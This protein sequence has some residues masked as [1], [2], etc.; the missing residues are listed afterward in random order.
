MKLSQKCFQ[1]KINIIKAF[2]LSESGSI[3]RDSD[4]LE[5]LLS[6]PERIHRILN[7]VLYKKRKVGN[8]ICFIM[9][10]ITSNKVRSRIAKY[11]LGKGCTR[12]QKS[13]FMADLPVS[14]YNEINEALVEVQK[15]YENNDSILIVPLSEDYVKAM[16]VIG[17]QVDMDL[18]MH[19][20]TTLFF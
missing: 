19:V 18:M 6:L 11:L 1:E 20:K 17:Q 8:M 13:I 14:T 15:L 16:K 5:D 3:S 7:I 12:V 10:D 4:N 9:Y 2:G